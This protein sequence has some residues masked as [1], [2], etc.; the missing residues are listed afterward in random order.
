MNDIII[1][2]SFSGPFSGLRAPSIPGR[3]LWSSNSQSLSILTQL[4]L[5]SR[6]HFLPRH[7]FPVGHRWMSM[8]LFCSQVAASRQGE[9]HH[10][11]LLVVLQSCQQPRPLEDQSHCRSESPKH[12]RGIS[13]VQVKEKVPQ[14]LA[15]VQ[16]QSMV[17]QNG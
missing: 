7:F 12:V 14:P 10:T 16:V 17:Q 9:L 6:L 8:A 1:H 15:T 11:S 5:D 3:G 2:H 4:G 13:R